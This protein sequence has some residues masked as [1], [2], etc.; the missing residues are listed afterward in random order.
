MHVTSYGS[1][2]EAFAAMNEAEAAANEALTPG[3]IRL[4]DDVENVRY[5][6][7]ILTEYG[8]VIFG[9]VLPN[10]DLKSDEDEG[11]DVDANRARG[12]LT[13][14][15]F[16]AWEPTGEYGDTHVSQVIPITPTEFVMAE[17]LG[18][19]TMDALRDTPEGNILGRM[20]FDCE[21]AAQR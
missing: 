8:L 16:S 1:M 7:R 20:L 6:V 9:K 13:G 21:Q 2:D 5:W 12:Y 4:R 3:Q 14:N 17:R 11:F 18:W 15:A 10:A 19:P